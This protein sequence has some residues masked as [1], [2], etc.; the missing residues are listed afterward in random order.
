M[1]RLIGIYG[2]AGHGR[3]TMPLVLEQLDELGRGRPSNDR[4]VDEGDRLALDGALDR[5]EF[6]PHSALTLVREVE[7]MRSLFQEKKS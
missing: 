4:V 3:E 6:Q 7:L 2:A 5:V 1:T